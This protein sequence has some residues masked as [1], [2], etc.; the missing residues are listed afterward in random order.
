MCHLGA[1]DVLKGRWPALRTRLRAWGRPLFE[2]SRVRSAKAVLQFDGV[3]DDVG[4]AAAYVEG[5][6]RVLRD[7]RYLNLDEATLSS[8]EAVLRAGDKNAQLADAGVGARLPEPSG[9]RTGRLP[10]ATL[11]WASEALASG[12]NHPLLVAGTFF[13]RF[14]SA[15]PRSPHVARLGLLLTTL[16]LVRQGYEQLFYGPLEEV[17]ARDLGMLR[18]TLEKANATLGSNEA[19]L[20]PWLELFVG[21][22]ALQAAELIDFVEQRRAAPMRSLL[23]ERL[24]EHLERQPRMTMTEA[25]AV[26]G[27]NRNTVKIALRKLHHAKELSLHGQGRGAFYTL[28]G[29]RNG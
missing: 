29:P 8:F 16:L 17:L 2:Q 18:W 13:L 7:W 3:A 19:E 23:E 26:S 1:V 5:L 21:A 10:A 6:R 14:V 22:L 15:Q 20:S 25:V 11:K 12:G 24:I 27:A 28:A 4:A 9:E